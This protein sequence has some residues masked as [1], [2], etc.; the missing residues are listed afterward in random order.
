MELTPKLNEQV[1]DAI[2]EAIK[3]IRPRPAVDRILT[4]RVTGKWTHYVQVLLAYTP[5][6]FGLAYCNIDKPSAIKVK[7]HD[8]DS[9][10]G[11]HATAKELRRLKRIEKATER[12]TARE[13]KAKAKAAEVPKAPKTKTAKKVR[14][15]PFDPSLPTLENTASRQVKTKK[16]KRTP[17]DE[18]QTTD[19]K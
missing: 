17:A 4:A 9:K 8:A 10:C 1:M 12:K 5:D 19:V 16:S 11:R 13:Q 3:E 14:V 2:S 18:V 6:T 7:V 15:V